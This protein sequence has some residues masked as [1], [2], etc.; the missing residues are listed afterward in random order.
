MRISAGGRRMAWCRSRVGALALGGLLAASLAAAT[1]AGAATTDSGATGVRSAGPLVDLQ[2]TVANPADGAFAQFAATKSDGTMTAYLVIYGMNPAAAGEVHGAHVHT[3]PCVAGDGAAA[4]PHY[5]SG[6]P[7]SPSTEVWLDF[8]IQ[9]NGSA[10][11]TTTVPFV[12]PPGGA[13]SVVVHAAPTAP[14]GAAGARI[15]CLPVNF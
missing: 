4:G 6:G 1:S 7:P 12:I 11:S 2:P 9:P 3:G 15:A 13:M 5:N 10:Y 8:T 14:G